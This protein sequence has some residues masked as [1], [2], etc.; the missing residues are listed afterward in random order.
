MPFA[1]ARPCRSC[2]KATTEKGGYCPDCK[3]KVRQQRRQTE[4]WRQTTGARGGTI[5]IYQSSRWKRERE[6]FLVERPLCECDVCKAESRVTAATVVHH[7]KPHRGDLLL[8]WS[9]ENWSPRAKAC[10]DRE[11]MREVHERYAEGR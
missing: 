2:R 5:D 6:A 7:L 10:H 3:P 8:F 4:T 9:W 1:P 11:T